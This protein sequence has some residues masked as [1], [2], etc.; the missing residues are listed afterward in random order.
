MAP[1]LAHGQYLGSFDWASRYGLTTNP[2]VV[3]HNPQAF[4]QISEFIPWTN[5][6]WTQVHHGQL[7]L[8]NPYTVLGTPLAFNW[9][10]GTFG[11][12]ALLGYLFP[13]RLAYTVQVMATLFVAGTGVYVLGRVLRLGVLGCAMAATVYELSGPFQAWLGAP[14]TSVMSW[15]GWLFAATLVVVRGRHPARAIAFFAVVL[16]CAVYAGQP[17]TMVNLGSA[18]LVF[19]A[20]L[21]VTRVRRFGGS[22]PIRR[23]LVHTVLGVAAGAALS[24]PLLLPGLQLLPS[25]LRTGKNLSQALPAQSIVLNLFQGF[26]GLPVAGSRWFGSGYYVKTVAYLGVIAVVL[27][28]LAVV[29]A[30]KL[31]CRRPEVIAFG[32]VALSM[33]GI[34][35]VPPVESF[36]GALPLLGSVQWHRS[37]TAMAF[38]L[39]VLAGMGVDVLVRSHRRRVI[40][41]WTAYGFGAS[42]VLLVALWALGRGH[43]PRVEASI[44]AKSFIW[45]AAATALGLVVAGVLFLAHGRHG[46]HSHEGRHGAGAGRGWLG[47]GQGAA[48]TLLVCETAFLVTAGAPLWSSS[49]TY[50]APTLPEIALAKAVGTSVV[51]LGKN[52]CF[53]NQLGL[54]PDLNVAFRVKELAAYE[55]LLPMA[56]GSSWRDA[57][58]QTAA[59]VET[60]LVP[61]TVFCPAVTSASVARR[62]G[63][64]FILEPAGAPGPPGTIFVEAVGG[65]GL[66]RVPGASAAT[67]V[68]VPAGGGLPGPD[69]AGRSVPVTVHDPASWTINTDAAGPA[70]VRMRL[71][72][73][74]GWHASIDGRPL[75]LH[76]FAGVMLQA[77][78]PPGRHVVK[79]D[80]WPQ[81]FT[82]GIVLAGAAVVVLG[83]ALAYGPVRRRSRRGP[84]TG[85]T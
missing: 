6:A 52:T 68:P 47:L 50:L 34:V 73:V 65:E 8:W 32:A 80:Y 16:A 61:F 72:A 62:Y 48:A 21:L 3:I 25:S 57:T 12:P 17:D 83:A 69:A 18:L 24:A 71:T 28:V 42:A 39:A 49:S 37:T 38:A 63:V 56:Y 60:P 40:R 79:L 44:R 30:V 85:P 59:P 22:G 55:P 78:I 10:A 35:Y 33:A 20:V 14:I 13:L 76:D 64:G 82:A 77:L 41:V 74:P 36:L 84:V 45:P 9:Q 66:Y 15:A 75:A 43:L 7:P 70:V 53:S 67:L 5:L 4:D 19:V 31:R 51:G 2:G 29:A 81:T 27:A 26:D 58:G 11:V 23:P 46:R 1:A 54:V